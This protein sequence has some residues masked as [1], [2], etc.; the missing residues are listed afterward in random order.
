VFAEV[1][2]TAALRKRLE[3]RSGWKGVCCPVFAPPLY[4][5]PL[6]P[7]NTHTWF[8]VHRCALCSSESCD[9]CKYVHAFPHGMG[10]CKRPLQ[11]QVRTRL[12]PGLV[13]VVHAHVRRAGSNGL[14][15]A[16]TRQPLPC[17]APFDTERKRPPP[18]FA[19]ILASWPPFFTH[20]L[21]GR[22]FL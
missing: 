17:P 8:P 15:P 7:L 4:W 2:N 18:L 14:A 3:G 10:T 19:L 16:T 22:F 9:Q 1:V 5:P 12:S 21:M 11:L 13:C 20:S 6:Y